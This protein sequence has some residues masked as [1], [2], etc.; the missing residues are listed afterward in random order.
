M[1]HMWQLAQNWVS[2]ISI[3]TGVIDGA[4]I[5]LHRTHM[6]ISWNACAIRPKFF[7]G[8]SMVAE[9]LIYRVRKLQSFE[10]VAS[11]QVA[12]QLMKNTYQIANDTNSWRSGVDSIDTQQKAATIVA[13]WI[14]SI[15]W[16]SWEE[17]Q[18]LH[19]RN[20]VSRSHPGSPCYKPWSFK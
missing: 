9:S 13:I 14:G 20:L 15:W 10:G 11:R 5:W 7:Q 2:I 1:E 12:M 3:L 4:A 16:A 18:P 8:Q 6:S 17:I 19:K